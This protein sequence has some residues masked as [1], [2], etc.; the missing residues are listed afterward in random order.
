MKAERYTLMCKHCGRM[1]KFLYSVGQRCYGCYEEWLS[2]DGIKT[3][4]NLHNK[5]VLYR[6]K[7]QQQTAIIGRLERNKVKLL[8]I[9]FEL[10][11][12]KRSR[13]A[14]ETQS[15]SDYDPKSF[16]GAMVAF[17]ADAVQ[18]KNRSQKSKKVKSK[19]KA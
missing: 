9:I 6:K 12:E 13:I 5:L 16:I 18:I 1:V 11:E 3:L 2:K 8:A 19:Y 10:N 14:V 7:T 15:A 17:Q 4:R